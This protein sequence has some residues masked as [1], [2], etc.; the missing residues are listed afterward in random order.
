MP[1]WLLKNS[2]YKVKIEGNC[3]ERGTEEYNMA[4]GQRRSDEAKKYLLSMGIAIKRISTVT[5]GK[6]R[7]ID[8]GHDEEAW[9]KNRNDHFV[10]SLKK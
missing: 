8:P 3:D 10:I 4:L 1:D 2:E 9:A 5:Y 7:P 6:D